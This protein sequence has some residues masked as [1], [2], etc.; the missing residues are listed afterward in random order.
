MNSTPCQECKQ[1]KTNTIIN[2]AEATMTEADYA[3]YL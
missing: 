1:E 2:A 3:K